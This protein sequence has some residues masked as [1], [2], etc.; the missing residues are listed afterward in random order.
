M[1]FLQPERKRTVKVVVLL[2]L[3]GFFLY[4]IDLFYGLLMRFFAITTAFVFGLVL[5]LLFNLPL[6]FFERSF[7]FFD[8]N[9]ALKRVK[10]SLSLTLSVLLVTAIVLV[11]LVVIIPEV[12]GAV[13]RLIGRIPDLLTRLENWLMQYS[14]NLRQIL[15]FAETDESNVRD[16]LQR[17]SN[18][19]MGGINYSSNVVMSAAQMVVNVVVG[20]IFAI[21]LLYSKERIKGQLSRLTYAY[22]PPKPAARLLEILTLTTDTYSKFLGGQCLQAV[23]SSLIVW[24]CMTIFG[25]PYAILVAL[26]TFICAFIPI[27]GPYIA[28]L[29]GAL[30]VYTASPSRTL[31]FLLMYLIVQQLEG[32]LIYPRILS[33]AIDIP[34]IWVLVA[35]TIGGGIMGIAGMLL[36]IPLFAVAY[37]LLAQNVRRRTA[38]RQAEAADA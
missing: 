22:L 28:G 7:H 37:R 3:F 25:F 12:V 33:N 9:P 14:I 4:R 35:V 29:L 11:L 32:S 34:S 15:G 13:E 38:Q 21:Y 24:A 2:M 16:A 10:R 6:K 27:F 8:K 30:L 19:L 5:A 31:W 26:I 17:V 23:I 36:F 1:L 20:L 18:F